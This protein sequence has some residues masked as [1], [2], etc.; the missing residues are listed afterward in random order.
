MTLVFAHQ[1]GGPWPQ[2]SPIDPAGL[3]A[4]VVHVPWAERVDFAVHV[5]S[6]LHVSSVAL[7]PLAWAWATLHPTYEPVDDAEFERLLGQTAFC[8]FLTPTLD[9]PD[10]AAFQA[11]M[12]DGRTYWKADFSAMTHVDTMP[13][14]Y[15]AATVTLL[16]RLPGD[17]VGVRAIRCGEHVFTPADGPAWALAKYYALQG[18]TTH[19]V[20]AGHGWLHFPMDP[21]VAI[22][23]T[24]V[25]AGH[26]LRQLLEPHVRF[27]LALDDGVLHNPRTLLHNDVR[28][29]FTPFTGIG[30]T[31][32]GPVYKG[33]PGN[34]AYPGFRFPRGLPA[35][36]APYGPFLA[37]YYGVIRAF[38]AEVV[39]TLAPRDPVV[40]NWARHVSQWVPGFPDDGEVADPDVLTDALAFIIT[41]VSVMHAADHY[42][43]SAQPITHRPLRLR[44]P[45]PTSRD[46]APFRQADLATFDDMFRYRMAHEMFFKP[47]NVTLL[48]DTRYGFS[49][50]GLQDAARRFRRA[51]HAHDQQLVG[52]RFVPLRE[53]SASIQY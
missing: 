7:Q 24:A 39:A 8:K 4:A 20:L 34:S 29:P 10:V 32:L 18:A 1:H 52:P 2:P 16:E 28:E 31:L 48:A 36:P 5:L 38:V 22:T 37:G 21:I 40:A 11:Y 30:Y 41:D 53:I 27:T 42:D 12:D 23:Q 9:P 26:V 50:P 49:A 47:N 15:V 3:P 19:M 25:P 44:V 45:P 46:Q 51:L 13:G 43:F 6:R 35:V 14:T 17:R 33:V